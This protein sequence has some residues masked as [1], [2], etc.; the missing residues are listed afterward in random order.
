VN[1]KAATGGHAMR[2]WVLSVGRG[3]RH[4]AALSTG[5]RRCGRHT[6]E[7]STRVAGQQEW[8]RSESSFPSQPNRRQSVGAR[9]RTSPRSA[10]PAPARVSRVRSA[11]QTRHRVNQMIEGMRFGLPAGER[12]GSRGAAWRYVER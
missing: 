11:P 6:V 9:Q 3:T 2:W 10:R 8:Q 1:G 5:A 12:Q 7:L 4:G